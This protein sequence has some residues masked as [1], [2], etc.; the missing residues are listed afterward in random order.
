[1]IPLPLLC[2]VAGLV[3]SVMYYCWP[4]GRQTMLRNYARVL[5]E[6][7][8]GERNRVARQSLANYLRY[9]V[10]F[11]SSGK[12]SLEQRLAVG[13]ETPGFD[14]LD[15]GLARGR[16]AVVAPMHFGNWDLGATIAA[17]RGYSLT[18]VGET[19]GNPRLD[20]LVVGGREALGVRL[21]KM[22]KVGPSLVRSLRR[23]EMVATLID[24]P[25]RE[26]GVRVRFFGEEV[27]VP[28]GPARLALHTGAAIG[29]VAFPRRGPGRI[30]VLSNFDLDFEPTG[31]TAQDV[32]VLTQ[33]IM[34]A[35]EAYVRRY[36]EQWYMF[37]EFWE[38]PTSDGP[39]KEA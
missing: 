36:P 8:A 24:R 39:S 27:E 21:V 23:N 7:T 17:A 32:Q 15:R 18:V 11:A 10:E 4:Q 6:A 34:I 20:E 14:G 2:G 25:L 22:E 9:M 3:G 12:L 28:A 19:F 1:M 31:D 26:G 13:V 37:R 33:A 35:H 5:P 29:A 38:A 30:D 16:G